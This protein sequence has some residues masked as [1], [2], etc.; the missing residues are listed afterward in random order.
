MPISTRASSSDQDSDGKPLGRGPNRTPVL[1]YV[2][3]IEVLGGKGFACE[4]AD[5]ESRA[6]AKSRAFREE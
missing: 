5:P 1:A 4:V 3:G 6:D 2:F